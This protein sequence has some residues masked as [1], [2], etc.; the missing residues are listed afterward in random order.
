M[1]TTVTPDNFVE[2]IETGKVADVLDIKEQ[3][4]EPK[5]EVKDVTV[6]AKEDDDSDLSEVVR[7][8]IGKKHRQMKEAEEFAERQ[9]NE[10]RAAEKRADSLEQRLAELEPKSRLAVV[11]DEEPYPE[12]SDFQTVQEYIAACV[13]HDVKRERALEKAEAEQ[14]RRSA[15]AMQIQ[16]EFATRLTAF[17]KETPDF[18]EVTSRADVNLPEGITQYILESKQGPQ[19][20]YALAKLNETDP[21]ELNRI[22]SLK[23]IRAIDEIGQLVAP[24]AKPKAESSAAPTSKAP[25]PIAPLEGNGTGIQKDPAKMNF[26]EYR[27]YEEARR[28]GK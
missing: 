16:N 20:G 2:F 5:E 23:T 26:K 7:Q 13:K 8:K 19:I 27:A 1:S 14:Q 18:E 15:E 3:A 22:L 9:Y 4:K 24:I 25:A 6:E 28:R 11:K 10:R 17:M 12:Q 21:T